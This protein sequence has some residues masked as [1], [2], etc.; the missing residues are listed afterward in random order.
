MATAE[1]L[2]KE[3]KLTNIN[4]I[5]SKMSLSSPIL[6]IEVNDS[7]TADMLSRQSAKIRSKA[8]AIMYPPQELYPTIKSIENNCKAQR[9]KNPNLRY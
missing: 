1:F 6:W 4:I 7:Y 5:S 2:D 8:K 3:L 9:S